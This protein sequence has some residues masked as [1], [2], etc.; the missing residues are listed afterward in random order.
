M[1]ELQSVSKRLGAFAITDLNLRVTDG[2]YFIQLGPSGVGKTVLLELIAGLL[3]PDSGRILWR[4]EEITHRPPEAR[5]FAIVYQDY[6]LFPHLGVADNIAYG[7]KA[8]GMGRRAVAER[9][10][11]LADNLQIA[12]LLDRRPDT[13]SGGEQ[14]RVALARAL[15]TDPELLLLDEPL[16]AVD[17]AIRRQ[18]RK[19]LKR[20]HRE[21]GTT[22]FHV[23]HSA[24][25][26]MA[27]GDRVGV[28][29]EGRQRQVATPEQLFR[30][31]DDPEV[32]EFLGLRNLLPVDAV[33]DHACDCRG[34]RIH[35]SS[36]EEGISHIWIKPEEIV[37]SREPFASSARNQLLCR[38]EGCEAH[39]ALYIVHLV[40]SALRLDVLITYESLQRLEIER[41]GAIHATF[42]SSAVHCL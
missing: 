32:A 7:L 42:K 39:H 21:T 31:P 17:M 11:R 40:K 2:E 24:E 23:T 28:M 27:L 20:I 6:A 36:A 16:S 15:A 38:I 13:L 3:R 18:L 1:L 12:A 14:Q 41:G 19:L 29:L 37:L 26:A 30:H 9:V 25:E 35:V 5:R 4:G 33:V 8:A 34:E 10:A 22:F